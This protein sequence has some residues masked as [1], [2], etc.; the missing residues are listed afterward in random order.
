MIKILGGGMK[1]DKA[2]LDCCKQL[3][4]SVRWHGDL[5]RDWFG[6]PDLP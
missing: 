5:V 3:L 1:E 2:A 6:Q 4:L